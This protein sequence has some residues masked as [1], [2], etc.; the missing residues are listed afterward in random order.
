MPKRTL[1]ILHLLLAMG[2]TSAPYNEH[3]L[4]AVEGQKISICT[5][6]KPTVT[7]PER[8]TLFAGNGTLSGFFRA[9]W[10][11]LKAQNYDVIHAHSVHVATLLVFSRYIL[12]HG[13]KARTVY[14]LHSSYPNYKLTNKLMLLITTVFFEKIVCCSYASLESLPAFFKKIAGHR[15]AVVQ[16]GLDL[17]RVDTAIR[18]FSAPHHNDCFTL[19]AIGRLIEVKNPLTIERAF[20]LSDDGQ[21]RLVFVGEGHLRD[22]LMQEIAAHGLGRRVQFTGL[23]ARELVYKYLLDT[24]LFISTSFIEGLPVAVLEAM[25]CGRPILLSDIPAHREIAANIDFIP[26]VAA[27]DA[28]GFAREIKRF[29]KMSAQERSQIGARCRQLV[30]ERFSLTKMRQ[31]YDSIYLQLLAQ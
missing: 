15:L 11:A 26:L 24:D 5:F 12:L 14:T 3:C 23:I 17:G 7:P 29:Q 1:N 8:I 19:T 2:E 6:F 20:H 9:L 18:K 25:A 4:P 13:F 21:S 31:E 16:N 10:A 30:E 27:P 28:D 22:P